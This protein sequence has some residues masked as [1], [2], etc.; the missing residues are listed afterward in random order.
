MS[1]NSL[2]PDCLTVCALGLGGTLLALAGLLLSGR[3][4]GWAPPLAAL[5]LAAAGAAG[6]AARAEQGYWA[7]P[8]ALAAVWGLFLFLRGPVPARL[9]RLAR[10]PRCQ[11]ALLL[12]AGP[13][14]MVWQGERLAEEAA[15]PYVP[16]ADMLAQVEY[17]L[18]EVP[19]HAVTDAGNPLPLFAPDIAADRADHLDEEGFLR[20]QPLRQGVIR[21][22]GPTLAYNCHGWVFVG[23]RHW[24]RGREVEQVLRD[25]D[26]RRVSQPGPGDVAVYRDD[27]G[28]VV[29]SG[30]VRTV[31]AEGLVLVESKWGGRGRYLHPPDDHCYGDVACTYYRSPRQGH[32]LALD[33]GSPDRATPPPLLGG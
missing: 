5:A 17:T 27:S 29:H 15:P 1:L 9:G 2:Q 30:L 33:A 13:A 3:R 20:K 24:L 19:A 10:A 8:L 4:W 14:L 26:Y 6:A 25:N 16:P 28:A 23:G 7:P 22:A 32:L 31:T 21:T 12:V 18:A 11:W